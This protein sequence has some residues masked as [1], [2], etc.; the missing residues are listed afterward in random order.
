MYYFTTWHL[1]KQKFL[2]SLTHGLLREFGHE[3]RTGDSGDFYTCQVGAF[4]LK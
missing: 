2:E 3:A 1:G 4:W